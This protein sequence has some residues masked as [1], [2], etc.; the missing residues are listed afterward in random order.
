MND[1]FLD[2]HDFDTVALMTRLDSRQGRPALD[3]V[4]DIK[5][6]VDLAGSPLLT[7]E[8]LQTFEHFLT[9]SVLSGEK[10]LRTASDFLAKN[11]NF[12]IALFKNNKVSE[13]FIDTLLVFY[14]GA[15]I[16]EEI[17]TAEDRQRFFN[18]YDLMDILSR[19]T[20]IYYF[21]GQ[22]D[23]EH[24]ELGYFTNL[25]DPSFALQ[26]FLLR[27]VKFFHRGEFF[28]LNGIK[29]YLA[30][31]R[32][33]DSKV[34]INNTNFDYVDPID[35]EDQ[36]Y[37]LILNSENET[38][39]ICEYLLSNPQ[40]E[41][42]GFLP[43]LQDLGGELP[44][45]QSENP[46]VQNE[47]RR[48]E[49]G[50][51]INEYADVEESFFR[52]F[53]DVDL[54]LDKVRSM[55]YIRIPSTERTNKVEILEKITLNPGQIESIQDLEIRSVEDV[56]LVR[57]LLLD[58]P[59]IMLDR[60]FFAT[61]DIS[62]EDLMLFYSRTSFFAEIFNDSVDNFWCEF[63]CGSKCLVLG[64]KQVSSSTFCTIPEKIC[65][66]KQLMDYIFS[67]ESYDGKAYFIED[68]GLELD[69]E[70]VVAL[71][72]EFSD[73]IGIV[74]TNQFVQLSKALLDALPETLQVLDLSH[75][76][77]SDEGALLL[78]KYIK[79]GKFPMLKK[80][81]LHHNFISKKALKKLYK[82]DDYI[83][84]SCNDQ[85]E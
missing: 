19:N 75:N 20:V 83:S 81:V 40:D 35:V 65:K 15:R 56:S 67:D 70:G 45:I 38:E 5:K 30:N 73:C 28:D 60:P 68:K 63:F 51:G 11:R 82:S 43:N 21:E 80:I 41:I 22:F 29:F 54:L 24:Y 17:L 76:E 84:W 4:E 42:A 2:L 8:N 58:N 59:K 49:Y 44:F 61:I 69:D 39:P 33:F 10:N 31:K 48:L 64:N 47:N 50:I 6:A 13:E 46:N 37:S 66:D 9:F 27:N 53:S 12:L 52:Q 3:I 7:E 71:S 79:K 34:P 18:K 77:I 72:D 78:A 62:Y 57:K 16:V 74:I 23:I 32:F 14:E 25:K 1:R 26:L 55:R 85:L 36:I